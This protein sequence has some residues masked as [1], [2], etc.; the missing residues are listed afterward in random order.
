MYQFTRLEDEAEAAYYEEGWNFVE[1]ERGWQ[2][3]LSRFS[4]HF[5]VE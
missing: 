1:A 3:K 2:R 4:S 5:G